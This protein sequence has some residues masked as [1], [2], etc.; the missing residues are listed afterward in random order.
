MFPNNLSQFSVLE[1]I[2]P[3]LISS[4]KQLGKTYCVPSMKLVFVHKLGSFPGEIRNWS[5]YTE[6]KKRPEKQADHSRLVGGKSNKKENLPTRL[7]LGAAR[8]PPGTSD[9]SPVPRIEPGMS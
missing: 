1:F 7:V 9:E 4:G 5:W 2:Q 3:F 8:S 6:G